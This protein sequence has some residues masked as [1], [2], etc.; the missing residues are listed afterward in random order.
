VGVGGKGNSGVAGVIENRE[1]A[2]GYVNQSF[3]QRKCC[4]LLHLKINQVSF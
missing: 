4:C 3:Y 1:G 2:I